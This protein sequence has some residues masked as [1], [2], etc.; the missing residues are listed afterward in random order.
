METNS[1][2]TAVFQKYYNRD[3]WQNAI[4][5]HGKDDYQH[6]DI[7]K[8]NFFKDG[9]PTLL[10][11][12]RVVN[13]CSAFLIL[14]HCKFKKG[15]NVRHTS[16]NQGSSV[17]SGITFVNC[18]FEE[19]LNLSDSDIGRLEF[20]NCRGT[21]EF[22][23]SSTTTIK[24]DGGS[25]MQMILHK[26][27]F[28]WYITKIAKVQAS[29]LQILNAK[30]TATIKDDTSSPIILAKNNTG[31]ASQFS[32][33]F[34]TNLESE[35]HTCIV[36]GRSSQKTKEK[37]LLFAFNGYFGNC[38]SNNE[39]AGTKKISTI[40]D[41]LPVGCDIYKNLFT[42]KHI[43]YIPSWA[44]AEQPKFCEKHNINVKKINPL[45]LALKDDAKM[46][47]WDFDTNLES[48]EK[49]LANF[50]QF[51]ATITPRDAY[52][53]LRQLNKVITKKQN[54]I[55]LQGKKIAMPNIGEANKFLHQ[56][57]TKN[58]KND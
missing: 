15:L 7:D 51:L 5:L 56:L 43:P 36:F 4:M 26:N 3:E 27:I 2:S 50:L 13:N 53:H 47:N 14:A 41:V 40:K 1:K 6:T 54:A 44:F 18:I 8:V 55:L 37:T 11:H 32:I 28:N 25:E 16:L 52:K 17:Y 22:Y 20:I 42:T 21:V 24:F 29:A 58:Q 38:F 34:I 48:A 33:D 57:T 46:K 10:N 31:T 49:I 45:W 23:K 39:Y 19:P 35:N 30:I 9:L 12:T